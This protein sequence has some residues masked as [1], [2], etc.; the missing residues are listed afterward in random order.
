MYPALLTIKPMLLKSITNLDTKKTFLFSV[1]M[2]LTVKEEQVFAHPVMGNFDI[3][4][5]ARE[6]SSCHLM[7]E[8]AYFDV[9]RVFMPESISCRTCIIPVKKMD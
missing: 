9:N 6:T 2:H 7:F 8:H 4:I 5:T 1:K 3:V